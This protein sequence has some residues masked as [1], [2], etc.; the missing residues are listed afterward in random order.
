MILKKIN[1]KNKVTF[2]YFEIWLG[3][4]RSVFDHS[5]FNINGKIEDQATCVSTQICPWCI[6][7]YGLYG[8][9]DRTPESINEEIRLYRND[10]PE[11]LDFTCGVDGCNNGAAD[12]IDIAWEDGFEVTDYE[13]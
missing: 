2:D 13:E 4:E 7:K 11:D 1:Y 3:A 5:R 6:K 9:V 10:E 8:E 12:Y